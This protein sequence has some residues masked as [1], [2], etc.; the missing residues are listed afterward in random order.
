MKITPK[1]KTSLFVSAIAFIG[2]VVRIP[3]L[4][5][6]YALGPDDGVYGLSAVAVSKGQVPFRQTFSSQGGY[7][8]ELITLPVR[9]FSD[10]FWAPR[11]VSILAGCAI[12]ICIFF[13]GKRIM[14]ET[15][16]FFAGIAVVL[17][18]TLLRTTSAITSDGLVCLISLLCIIATLRFIDKHTIERAVIAGVLLGFGTGTKNVFMIPAIVFMVASTVKTPISQRFLA[19]AISVGVF[20]APF[21]IFGFQEVWD[22]SV[23]YHLEKNDQLSIS[24][25]INKIITTISTFDI[26]FVLLFIATLIGSVA[27]ILQY[28]GISQHLKKSIFSLSPDS[29][30]I[31]R[32]LTLFYLLPTALVLIFQNPLFRNHLAIVMPIAYLLMIRFMYF[33][34]IRNIFKVKEL[35]SIRVIGSIAFCVLA[36]V[37]LISVMTVNES[38]Y[39]RHRGNK[40]AVKLLSQLNNSAIVLTDDPG[41]VWTA[42]LMVPEMMTDA[43]RYRFSSKTESIRLTSNDFKNKVG[44]PNVCAAVQSHIQKPELLDIA[45]WVPTSWSRQQIGDYTIWINPSM[46]CK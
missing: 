26:V 14:P 5:K 10:S 43:S 22:Q 45:S 9:I 38:L 12:G 37:G 27:L 11:V 17:S 13:I 21:A 8:L 29:G 4:S 30:Y 16:S 32:F 23:I 24:K 31:T 44:K 40:E 15:W 35:A 1:L 3:A 6:H 33:L 19:G 41:L 46:D 39:K 20:I 2:F 7:F 42:G 28:H 25:N 18:G 36:A 34:Y